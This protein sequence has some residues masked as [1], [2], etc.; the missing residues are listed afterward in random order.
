[1]TDPIIE[2]VQRSELSPEEFELLRERARVDLYFLAKTVLGYK[3]LSPNLHGHLCNWLRR[4]EGSQYRCVLLPR[5][6]F[7]STIV[8]VSLNIQRALRN[9]N[10]RIALVH[11]S[12]TGAQRFLEEVTSHFLENKMLK[13]LFPEFVPDKRY[14]RI[15]I[16]ELELPRKGHWAEPTFDALGAGARGQG[17]HYDQI[18][19]DDIFGDKARDSAIESK[20]LKQW[21]D[22]IQS[23]L[24]SP[25]ISHIDVVG[26]RYSLDD[27][28]GHIFE[29]YGDDMLKYIRRVEETGEDGEL[30]PI[31]PERFTTDS[32]RILK[33]NHLVFSSQYLN[34]PVAGLVEFDREWLQYFKWG[35]RRRIVYY[36]EKARHEV[37]LDDC[38]KILFVDPARKN[39]LTGLTVTAVD[40]HMHIFV[41][42]AIK[43]KLDDVKF[44]NL[45]FQLVLK[46]GLRAVAVE[47]VLFS[48]LY[49]PWIEAEM[50]QRNLR[51]QVIAA[52]RKRIGKQY[53]EKN[54]HILAL[55]PYF[56]G[57]Q[58]FFDESH[59]ELI[60]EFLR[61]GATEDIHLLDSLAYGPENSR[62]GTPIA[63]ILSHE[64]EEAILA[65]RDIHTGYSRY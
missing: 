10:K 25:L 8:T 40:Q 56:A 22:N 9:S 13:M 59:E 54:K 6:H 37:D 32:L 43:E 62:P 57:K 50:K 64:T 12:A 63:K 60:T 16:S 17:R 42:D 7:K 18:T 24:L 36:E 31:F 11:E 47:A 38:D 28:Y 41:V 51:F 55:A 61:F 35:S 33:K 27:I 14:Q 2:G 15:N 29:N 52:K 65:S 20:R 45:L 46:W 21:F 23:F 1:M 48:E 3:D 30:V 5:A 53:E 49:K 34:D 26:T 39:G 44:L 19:A 4:N 58:I